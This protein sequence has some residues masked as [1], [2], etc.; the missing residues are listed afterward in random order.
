MRH[1]LGILSPFSCVTVVLFLLD[2]ANPVAEVEFEPESLM[3]CFGKT[4]DA[5]GKS[6][7][8]MEYTWVEPREEGKPG[9]FLMDKKNG[10][11]DIVEK[12][13]I[14][15]CALY[16]GRM[17]GNKVPYVSQHEAL[18]DEVSSASA[19]RVSRGFDAHRL[20]NVSRDS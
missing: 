2:P 14:K 12:P 16:Y 19:D 3:D 6:Y 13:S 5:S 15:V 17:P 11:I 20:G 1:F 8:A 4:E 9:H 10:F 7:V 18:F